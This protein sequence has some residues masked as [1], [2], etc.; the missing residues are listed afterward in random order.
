MLFT[1]A[2]MISCYRESEEGDFFIWLHN[3]ANDG[4]DTLM[5]S[6]IKAIRIQMHLREKEIKNNQNSGKSNV[7]NET[8]LESIFIKDDG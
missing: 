1:I 6:L 7:F 8:Y 2:F 5:L 4:E 3:S